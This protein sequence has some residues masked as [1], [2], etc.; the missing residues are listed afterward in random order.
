A[1]RGENFNGNLFAKKAVEC[2]AGCLMLDT[3]PECALSVPIILVKDTLNALQR[4]AKWYRD[5]LE[6]KVIGI[7]GSNGKT[8]TKDF[9]RS[10]LSECFQVNATK[11]NLNNHIGL[12]LSVLATEE[13]DEVCIFEM[14]M[15][16]AGEIAPL[17][18]IASPDLGIITNV[19]NAFQES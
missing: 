4:L 2:G 8:S 14:G 9:T 13:T 11:G 7:T 16:H 18:E 3:L 10:V 15:N 17:C 19:G 12:P 6:V 5:Q 1:L